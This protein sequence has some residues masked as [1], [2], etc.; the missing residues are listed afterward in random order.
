MEPCAIS[1]PEDWDVLVPRRGG[2]V[3]RVVPKQS[4]H[5]AYGACSCRLGTAGRQAGVS[6]VL[7]MHSTDP[8]RSSDSGNLHVDGCEVGDDVDEG[9]ERLD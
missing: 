9:F 8:T 6:E 2:R 3:G 7:I 1:L 5:P 4:A